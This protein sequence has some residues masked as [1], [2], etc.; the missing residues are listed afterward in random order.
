MTTSDVMVTKKQHFVKL[1]RLLA[2]VFYFKIRDFIERVLNI[3]RHFCVCLALRAD[4]WVGIDGLWIFSII[5]IMIAMP[6]VY[7]G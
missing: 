4:G 7:F 6:S 2:A 3:H 1:C 5:A